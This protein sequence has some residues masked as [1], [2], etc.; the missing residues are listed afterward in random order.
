MS[1]EIAQSQSQSHEVAESAQ[2][3][4]CTD[5][6][7][8]P[9]SSATVTFSFLRLSFVSLSLLWRMRI[10]R[11]RL[12]V[13]RP[14]LARRMSCCSSQVDTRVRSSRNGSNRRKRVLGLLWIPLGAQALLHRGRC[15]L[16]H[17][18]RRKGRTSLVNCAYCVSYDVCEDGCMSGQVV[19]AGCRVIRPPGNLNQSSH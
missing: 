18:R 16:L 19:Y 4:T 7:Q 9:G 1:C 14:W 12:L 11:R 8:R 6:P 13:Q 10:G 5:T 17:S 3:L 15:R 2:P